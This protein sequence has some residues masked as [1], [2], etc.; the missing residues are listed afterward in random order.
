MKFS[1]IV[2]VYN[3]EAYLAQCVDSVLCQEFADFELILVDDGSLD[4]SPSI[5]DMYA[6]N[7]RRVTVVHQKNGGLS[8]A[9]NTGIRMASGDYLLFMDSDDYWNSTLVLE[10]IKSTLDTL[11]AEIVHFGRQ[12]YYVRQ[13]KM[14]EPPPRTLST[15]NGLTFDDTINRLVSNGELTVSACVMAVSRA[16]IMN[17]NLFFK[18][19]IKTEDL[20]WAIR[21][22]VCEPRWAFL[23][24]YFYV[25]RYA[26]EGSITSTIDYKHLCDYC[27]ILEHS[28]ALV[29]ATKDSV[30]QPLMSYLL[31]HCLIVSAL[32]Y[33]VILTAEQRR[34]LL[35]RLKAVCQGRITRYTLSKKVKLASYVY[36]ILGFSGMAKILGFYLNNRRR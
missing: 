21:L 8:S 23:D 32:V 4:H 1:V 16:F 14:A 18:E 12:Y 28:V 17:H 15:Y 13:N 31:Y 33:R 7:D 20:E 29:E 9:R 11:E 10:K 19:G 34:E 35:L 36:R 3:V 2:P 22:Y 25:Y 24:D 30:K 6:Q 27:W 26:R 5:C